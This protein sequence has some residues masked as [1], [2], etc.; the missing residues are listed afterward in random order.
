MSKK[1]KSFVLFVFLVSSAVSTGRLSVDENRERIQKL[2][3]IFLR[4]QVRH[5]KAGRYAIP[6]P[7]SQRHLLLTCHAV[8][9]AS[10]TYKDVTYD[11]S[12]DCQD[13]VMNISDKINL[14]DMD[15]NQFSSHMT[16]IGHCDPNKPPEGLVVAEMNTTVAYNT[17]CLP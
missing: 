8:F 9:N 13:G 15:F 16:Y 6:V 14:M 11:V 10:W 3:E 1:Q 12:K 4:G 2:D 5:N 17:F 7:I